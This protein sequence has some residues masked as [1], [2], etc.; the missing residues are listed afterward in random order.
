MTSLM[1]EMVLT[2]LVSYRTIFLGA[3]WPGTALALQH[4]GLQGFACMSALS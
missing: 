3:G 4:A 1:R 2:F